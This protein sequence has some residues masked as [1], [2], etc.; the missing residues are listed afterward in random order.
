[1]IINGVRDDLQSAGIN[2]LRLA[3]LNI[4]W[5]ASVAMDCE[6]TWPMGI[7]TALERSLTIPLHGPIGMHNQIA[8][9]MGPTWGPSGSCRPPDGPHVGPMNLAMRVCLPIGVWKERL[10]KS[11]L[12]YTLHSLSGCEVNGQQLS[13][14]LF[15]LHYLCEYL[16]TDPMYKNGT[17]RRQM[18]YVVPV[19]N[20]RFSSTTIYQEI[21]LTE[22]FVCNLTVTC[23][24]HHVWELQWD[25][26]FTPGVD[27][28]FI[29][30][31]Q[32]II[33]EYIM[34]F[35]W[36]SGQHDYYVCICR[37]ETEQFTH[38]GPGYVKWLQ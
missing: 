25:I 13:G 4:G 7:A 33:Y 21:I 22:Y 2:L 1:M 9:F 15:R 5:I 38:C 35:T 31:I 26:L 19:K 12:S 14:Y 16:I 27:K 36:Q 37:P 8:K 24:V 11:L 28:C 32:I 6:S 20:T 23:L 10:W 34:V 18:S 3:G 29:S 30:C 17:F